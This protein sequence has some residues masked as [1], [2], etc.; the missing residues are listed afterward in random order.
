MKSTKEGHYRS[1]LKPKLDKRHNT[2]IPSLKVD[3]FVLFT[4]QP[5]NKSKGFYGPYRVI[6]TATQQGILKPFWSTGPRNAIKT[7]SIGNVFQYH[8]R[9]NKS[10][11]CKVKCAKNDKDKEEDGGPEGKR[12]ENRMA[13]YKKTFKRKQ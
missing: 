4:R 6:K 1:S 9:M 2:S 5:L 10:K 12:Q 11:V 3:D 13:K 7:A 8:P